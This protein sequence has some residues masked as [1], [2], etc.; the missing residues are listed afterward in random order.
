MNRWISTLIALFLTPL[1][2]S[3]TQVSSAQMGQ[4]EY[5]KKDR[6]AIIFYSQYPPQIVEEAIKDRMERAGNKG[7]ES[8][9]FLSKSS[10]LEYKNA[11][12]PEYN[13]R[14]VDLVFKVEPRSRKEKDESVIYLIVL[15]G[16]DNFATSQSDPELFE[17]SKNFLVSNHS[18]I[19]AHNLELEIGKQDEAVK[20]AEKKLSILQEDGVDLEKKIKELQAKLEQNKIEI[21]KQNGEVEKQKG[22]LVGM[23][24]KRKS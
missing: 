3:Q 5:Q 22:S 4:V 9:A 10:F 12:I 17:S 15:K 23:K 1:A 14:G 16:V 2:F 20:K 18:N 11:A 24:G 21:E 7:S 6:Q 8:K 19:E 13:I